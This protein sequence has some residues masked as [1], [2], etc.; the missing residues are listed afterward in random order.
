M[1]KIIQVI[2]SMIENSKKITEI[3]KKETNFF[4]L[5]K[6]YV[7]SIIQWSN[8]V[9]DEVKYSLIYYPKNKK[10]SELRILGYAD[11]LKIDRVFYSTDDFKTKEAFE[12]FA[13]LYTMIKE[14][15]YGID[16]MFDDILE[17]S[18]QE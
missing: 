11:M 17:D 12:S 13:Q 14:K 16:K 3:E 18:E 4:F 6:E 7:W 2:N 15:Y 8:D 1:S 10:I 5:Y 9:T